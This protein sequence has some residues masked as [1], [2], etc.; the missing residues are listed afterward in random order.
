M[1]ITV[2]QSNALRNLERSM[3]DFTKR[4]ERA[5]NRAVQ[6]ATTRSRGTWQSRL[7]GRPHVPSRPGRP[8]TGGN[9]ARMISWQRE[10][11]GKHQYVAFQKEAL[12]ARAPYWLIQEIG[13]GQSATILDT[14]TGVSVRSQRGRRISPT[15]VFA[16]AKGAY[17]SPS[18]SRRSDQIRS[19]S[20]VKN[21]PL[22]PDLEG[23]VIKRE[24]E[25]KHYIREGGQQAN[26]QYRDTLMTLARDTFRK[27][28]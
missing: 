12:E 14:Q 25:G 10:R 4:H 11:Q 5:L 2:T 18:A 21:A 9:F 27:R 6:T 16:D 23:I 7:S 26:A 22:Q 20:D 19:V 13:T 28:Q 15:L 8:T 17:A 1:S 24:I 3:R